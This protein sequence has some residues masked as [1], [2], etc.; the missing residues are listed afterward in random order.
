MTF[1]VMA[2]GFILIPSISAYVQYTLGYPRA[3]L[4][5]L[6]LCGG[7]VSF[8]AT[9]VAGRLIDRFGSFRVGSFGTL[10]LVVAIFGGFVLGPPLLPVLGIFLLLMLATRHPHLRH[11]T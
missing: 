9:Q 2:A 3:R 7:A 8:F 10:A 4:G 5:L 6:Y 11:I 1:F